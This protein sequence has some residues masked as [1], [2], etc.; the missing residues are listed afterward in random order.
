[1]KVKALCLAHERALIQTFR[2]F[3]DDPYLKYIP[4]TRP[5]IFGFQLGK[6]CSLL[7]S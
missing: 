2:L 4:C 1:M 5:I 7:L 3:L 6:L